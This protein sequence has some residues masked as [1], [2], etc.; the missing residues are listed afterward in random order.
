MRYTKF[1]A[2]SGVKPAGSILLQ[3]LTAI[4]FASLFFAVLLPGPA[5]ATQS[6]LIEHIV[7]PSATDPSG[8]I[9]PTLADHYAWVNPDQTVTNN[10]LLVYLPGNDGVPANALL[11]QQLAAQLGYNVIGLMYEDGNFLGGLCAT[12]PDPNSCFYNAHYEIVYGVDVSP[13]LQV[14]PANSIVNLLTKFLQYLDQHYPQEGWSRFLSGSQSN[15][16]PNW[17]QIALSGVSQGAGNSA[18]IA[19][20][21]VV[22]RVVMFSGVTDGIPTGSVSWLS[23]HA[24]P[25]DRYWGLAHDQ[26]PAYPHIT[27]NWESLGM[28]EFGGLVQV[29]NSSPPYQETHRLFTDLKPHEGP[30]FT[31]AHPSTVIDSYTPL[32]KGQPVLAP[33]WQYLITADSEEGR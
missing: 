12:D 24:T 26:D 11:F 5:M 22:P 13:K 29:E 16:H 31:N 3:R 1:S 10:Q 18:M 19:R 9:D 2:I 14:S 23:T 21:H 15:L 28:A 17:S 32:D 33:A 7:A 20:D 25:S 30:G 27:A 8:Q 6:G 4:A